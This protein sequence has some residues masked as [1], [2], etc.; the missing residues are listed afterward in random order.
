M[1]QRRW[2]R[3]RRQGKWKNL[4]HQRKNESSFTSFKINS[5]FC[6]PSFSSKSFASCSENIVEKKLWNEKR[7]MSYQILYLLSWVRDCSPF[8]SVGLVFFSQTFSPVI[9]SAYF[10]STLSTLC[11][12]LAYIQS[13]PVLFLVLLNVE[14]TFWM[15]SK[16]YSSQ[17]RSHH[18]PFT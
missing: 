17:F 16:I 6:D 4:L 12:L 18:P 15:W 5:G 11:H 2:W 8:S 7:K 13:S 14:K 10:I 3:R 1:W 9:P